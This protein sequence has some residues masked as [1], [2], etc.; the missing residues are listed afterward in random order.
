MID[1]LFIPKKRITMRNPIKSLV[2][3]AALVFS[4]GLVGAKQADTPHPLAGM[5]LRTIGPAMISGRISDFAFH[6]EHKQVFYVATSSGNLWKTTNNTI[7]WEPIFDGEGSYSLGVVELDPNNP[8]VVWAGSGENNSQ[9]SVAYGDGVYKSTDGGKTWRN[10][11]LKESNHISQIWISPKD[12]NTV[13]V[14]AQGPLWSNGGDRGLYKTTD[15]GENWERILHID[16]YTGVNEFVIDPDNHD[17]IVASSYQRRRHVWTLINGGP[18]SG[19]HKSTDGG[20]TWTEITAGLPKDHMG[21]IGLANAPSAPRTIYAIIEANDAEKGVYRSLDFG[22]NWHKQ[23][24]YMTNSPQYYNELVVDPHN[25]ERIYSLNTFTNISEDAGKT[26]TP[27]SLKFRHV[28]DHALWID[29]DNTDHLYIGG[30]GGVYETWDRGQT[31]RHVR[32]LPLGQFYRIQAD[33]DEPFYNICGGTQD[34]N[35]L[36]APSRTEVIH[37]VTNADWRII[38]GGDGY[39]PQFDPNDP[40]IIY[41]QYQYGGLARYDKRTM[42]RVFI[43]PHPG[44]DEEAYNWNWNT[45]LLLSPHHDTRLYYGAKQLFRSDDRGDSWVKISPDLTQQI[46]RNELEVMDRVWGVDTIAKNV[47]TSKYGSLIGITESPVQ[48]DL[49]MVGTDD[50]VISVSNNGGGDWTSVKKFKGVPDMSY[51]SDVLFSQHDVNV[52]YATFDNHKRGDYKPYVLKSTDQGKSWKS[53]TGN[54]PERGSTHTIVEDHVDPNLLFVGTEFGVFF[55]QNGGDS[56]HELTRLPTISVR[57]LDIQQRENDLIIGT[58]GRGVYILDDYTP[59]RFSAEK[60]KSDPAT[61]FPI[62]DTWQ[63]IEGDLFDNREKGSSGSEFY[64][65]PNP[66]LGVNITYYLKDSFKTLQKQRRKAEIAIEKEGGDTPYPSWDELREEDREEAPALHVLIEDGNG[67]VV[68][69]V[70]AKNSK[71]LNQVQWDMRYPAPDPVSLKQPGFVPYWVSPP[72]GPL[73][74]PGQYQATL[75]VREQGTVR[76]LSEAI[77]FTVKTLNNSPEI[78]SNPEQVLA[79]KQQLAE[80][81]RRTNGANRALGEIDNRIKHLKVAVDSTPSAT[82]AQASQVRALRARLQDLQVAFRGDRTVSSR[83]EAVP[84]SISQRVGSLYGGLL[85]SQ[86]D[87]P[88]NY[89]SSLK[90]A[91]QQLA[92][93]LEGLHQLEAD[94]SQFESTMEQL[95]APWTP[96]RL[97]ARQ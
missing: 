16:Q 87:I 69:R 6:P 35:S 57:D 67:N 30:D 48:A 75:M 52:A 32:N 9:R 3:S 41:A 61:V 7:T 62:R 93:G 63:Y 82:E 55:T 36:C 43:A 81:Q 54:L 20:V 5:P 15:G 27:L 12:S 49:L 47:S 25:P 83:Q 66:P 72:M 68:K 24:S 86:S 78:T 38:L 18:G 85:E 77:P 37:G 46:D 23:S 64:T 44:A 59:L 19:I 79:F 21:R 39:E 50:G 94:L 53:I 80:L 40:N 4:S 60:I 10:M 96:G 88:G 65:A 74:V 28:D 84:W 51:V 33:N 34:N 2:L 73:A 11:G 91:E 95:G 17:H 70:P 56:W 76:A 8:E 14:A 97:P 31:W 1:S 89:R 42:E 22:Q 71:G 58:F 29:P 26:W 45:P 92:S 13:L 90:I